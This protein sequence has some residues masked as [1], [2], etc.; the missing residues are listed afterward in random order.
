[1][2][3]RFRQSTLMIRAWVFA[4]LTGI[5]ALGMLISLFIPQNAKSHLV[6]ATSEKSPERVTTQNLTHVEAT[7]PKEE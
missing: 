7:V 4:G 3:S 5:M 6:A 2:R 1:M